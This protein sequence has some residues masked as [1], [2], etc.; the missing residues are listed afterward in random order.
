MTPDARYLRAMY[1]REW[2]KKNPE[3]SRE[4][5]ERAWEKKA[6]LLA[7]EREAAKNEKAAQE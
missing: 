3:K 2:R 1:Q 5:R 6:R 7:E 4:Y